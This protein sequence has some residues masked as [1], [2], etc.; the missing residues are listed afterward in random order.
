[1]TD[2]IQAA[3]RETGY[4]DIVDPIEDAMLR[5]AVR[6]VI[7]LAG[8]IQ[9]SAAAPLRN[10]L[11]LRWQ[12]NDTGRCRAARAG[13]AVLF[14]AWAETPP[15][16]GNATVVLT[17]ATALQGSTE[18]GRLSITQGR[19]VGEL[20]LAVPVPAGAWFGVAVGPANGAGSVSCSLTITTGGGA[21]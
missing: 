10:P 18:I 2:R 21:A 1:M 4:W 12:P 11:E 14:A 17:M 13:T 3:I 5:A 6:Q 7:D 9:E 16:T 15:S 20:A 8:G 19:N